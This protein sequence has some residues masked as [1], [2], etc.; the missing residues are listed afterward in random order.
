MSKKSEVT[1]AVASAAADPPKGP[2]RF[3]DKVEVLGRV[4]LTFPTVW[5]MMREGKFPHSRDS[6]TSK[7]MWLEDEIEQWIRNRPITVLKAPDEK[8]GN[9]S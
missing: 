2:A 7:A 1:A 4:K 5:K 9:T 3:L 6:G 8:V